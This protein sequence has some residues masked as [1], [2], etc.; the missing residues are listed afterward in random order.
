MRVM[1]ISR[2]HMQPSTHRHIYT[3]VKHAIVHSDW[4]AVNCIHL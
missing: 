1:Y 3:F 4:L 2:Y